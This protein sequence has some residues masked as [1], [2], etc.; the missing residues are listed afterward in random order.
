MKVVEI[1]VGAVFTSTRFF[2]VRISVGDLVADGKSLVM[3]SGF[4]V[5]VTI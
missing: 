5:W 1:A 3:N 4:G 2:L